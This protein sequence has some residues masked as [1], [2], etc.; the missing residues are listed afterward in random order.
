[1]KKRHVSKRI[2]PFLGCVV[3]LSAAFLLGMWGRAIKAQAEI[4][5]GLPFSM[6]AGTFSAGGGEVNP[7]GSGRELLSSIGNTSI[8]KMEGG[9]FKIGTGII[10]GV[11]A[12]GI[13]IENA[14]AFPNP[15]I[16]SHGHAG[17]TF[18]QLTTFA[19]I[20]IYTVAGQLVREIIKT[21]AATDRAAW[22]PVE[23]LGG[24]PVASGV[25]IFVIE[26][27]DGQAKTGKL[28]VIK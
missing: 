15:Y 13:N 18:S 17:I 8:A 19:T 7:A 5:L 9:D 28:M 20:R 25:Y 1:M 10:G 24:Q 27:G 22:F 16:P 3:I 14:H 26:S 12:S 23:N 21:D 11:G 2:F 6:V 4:L